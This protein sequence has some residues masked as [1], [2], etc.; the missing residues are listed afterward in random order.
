VHCDA[1]EHGGEQDR[2]ITV[3]M[4][5]GEVAPEEA[6][7]KGQRASD[8]ERQPAMPVHSLDASARRRSPSRASPID[9]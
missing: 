3:D 5:L 7:A 6:I 2:E 8:V 4:T 1:C 9:T